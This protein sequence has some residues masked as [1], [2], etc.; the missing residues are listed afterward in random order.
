MTIII[1][2]D[3]KAWT[4][5]K[6]P[7]AV[8]EDCRKLMKDSPKEYIEDW[9]KRIAFLCRALEILGDARTE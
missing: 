2:H 6:S 9:D 8:G 4:M 1:L 5:G 7:E 3:G